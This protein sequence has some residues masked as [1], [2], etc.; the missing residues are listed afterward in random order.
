MRTPRNNLTPPR[1]LALAGLAAATLSGC[2]TG[3]AASEPTAVVRPPQATIAP[4]PTLDVSALTGTTGL[5]STA[6]LSDSF[7]LGITG[8][9]EVKPAQDADMVFTVQG[10]VAEVLVKEGDTV[11]AGDVL[12]RLDTR[13]FDQQVAQAEAGLAAARAQ[14]SGL[15]EGP[16]A[17]DAAAAR[18]QIAQAQAALD[19]VRSAVKPQDVQSAEAGATA[20]AA[21]LQSTRDRLSLAK[22][23]A[24]SQVQQATQTLVQAQSRYA[25]AKYNWEF[26][27]DTGNDPIVPE[28]TNPQTGRRVD[29]KLSDGQL[30]NYYAQFVA[31]E[32]ALRQAEENVQLAQASYE[33]ARQAEITGIQAA[34]Q[35]VVQAQATVDKLKSGPDRSQL[36]QAQAG[37]AAAQAQAARLQPS[38]NQSQQSQVAAGVAQA[39]AALELAKL[40][41]EKAELRAPFDG[42]VAIVNVSPGDPSTVAGGPVIRLVDVSNLHVDVQISDVDIGQVVEGQDAVVRADALPDRTF[43]GTV[44][45]I[46]P[47]TSNTGTLRTYLVRITLDDQRGLRAGM[48]ARVEIT[49]E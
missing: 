1:L 29:N 10:V 18:A 46:A 16:R 6:A 13:T 36:A 22:T 40:T 15:S 2:A 24:E 35:Q 31:A 4:Q 25:Q 12:A 48:S 47:T 44:S 27:R 42:T 21:N 9:G 11:K 14:Q 23:Q 26:A 8:V 45:Y 20:A 5:T 33:T 28:S 17:A 43:N 32:A 39:E 3:G 37:V 49:A 34:E 41:R 19:Q 7:A 38:P 30:E